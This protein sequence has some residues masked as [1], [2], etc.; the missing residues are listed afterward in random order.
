MNV[1]FD[2]GAVLFTWR[3]VDLVAEA[4]PARASNEADAKQLSHAMFGHAD[5]HAFD[6]GLMEIDALI[7][8]TA[9]RLRLE[10]AAV[11]ALVHSIGGERLRP[12]A[13]SVAVLQSL[14]ARRQTGAVTGLYFLSNMPVPYARELEQKHSFLKHFD[15]G[16]FSGDVLCSKPD[17][18]IYSL[19]QSRYNLVPGNTVFIDDLK[20]NIDAARALGWKGIHF[21]SAAQLSDELRLQCGL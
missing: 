16:I 20:A 12:M 6:R 1:V 4:F 8:R 5:W 19:L 14:Y 11:H 17:P 2:F 9:N 3:P 15:G 18:G 13:E 7:S 10:L 21:Q